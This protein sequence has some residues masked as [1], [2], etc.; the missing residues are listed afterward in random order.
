M[1]VCFL[2]IILI[3]SE[4]KHANPTKLGRQSTVADDDINLNVGT[5]V[6]SNG[7]PVALSPSGAL[8][9]EVDAANPDITPNIA[10][11][12]SIDEKETDDSPFDE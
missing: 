5:A 11:V 10:T 6:G 4:Y 12:D 3:V 1:S 7:T 2:Q 9:T 8:Q